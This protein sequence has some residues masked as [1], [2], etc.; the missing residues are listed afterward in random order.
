MSGFLTA[1]P[2]APVAAHVEERPILP[3]S[4]AHQDD[5][6]TR[7]LTNEEVTWIHEPRRPPGAVPTARE[8]SLA[9]LFQDCFGRVALARHGT[10]TGLIRGRGALE[11]GHAFAAS[12]T[13]VPLT[14][15]RGPRLAATRSRRRRRAP[16]HPA[17]PRTP[18]PGWLPLP[19]R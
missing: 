7:D 1:D 15:A 12:V 14:G 6:F 4:V 10:G 18:G 17:P 2:R 11:R 8:D 9:L 5:R 16:S 3:G 19:P 13:R